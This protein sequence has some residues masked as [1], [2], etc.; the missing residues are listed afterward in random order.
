MTYRFFICVYLKDTARAFI[1]SL[2]PVCPREGLASGLD[3][4]EVSRMLETRSCFPY[5]SIGTFRG[6]RKVLRITIKATLGVSGMAGSC[7][8]R[9]SLIARTSSRA[10]SQ[11]ADLEGTVYGLLECS[12]LPLTPRV[13]S[14]PFIELAMTS[15]A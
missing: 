1:A 10:V 14:T 6:L 9:L 8:F 11:S 15:R 13:S 3:S 7:G 4:S 2:S 12:D 5:L